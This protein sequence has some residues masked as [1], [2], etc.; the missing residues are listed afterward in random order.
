[1]WTAFAFGL[2]IAGTRQVSPSG[3]T[4]V[5]TW[6]LSSS[7]P[8]ITQV[9]MVSIPS[10]FNAFASASAALAT[11]G[12]S[13]SGR[14]SP[15]ITPMAETLVPMLGEPDL[16]RTADIPPEPLKSIS[17][18]SA[19]SRA[20]SRSTTRRR[21]SGSRELIPMSNCTPANC[22]NSLAI[23]S[24]CSSLRTLGALNCSSARLASAARWLAS[25]PSA[26]AAATF[27]SDSLWSS[28][29]ASFALPMHRYSITKPTPI[30]MLAVEMTAFSSQDISLLKTYSAT[31]SR[32]IPARIRRVACPD[33]RSLSSSSVFGSSILLLVSRRS[34]YPDIS[35]MDLTPASS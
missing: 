27:S 14:D 5:K 25:A 2:G 34:S 21:S 13:F 12:S 24:I 1:M 18:H 28:A 8:G 32:T 35:H 6:P 11:M 16:V 20:L 23:R 9:Y 17:V 31:S 15:T 30:T 33:Q 7:N 19:F 29:V 4:A 22:L 3:P 10:A 26:S